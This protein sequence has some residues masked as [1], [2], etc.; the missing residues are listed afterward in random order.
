MRRFGSR[1]SLA[2]LAIV[3]SASLT[4]CNADRRYVSPDGSATWQL[5]FPPDAAP[6][7]TGEEITVFLVE[8]RIELPVR[9]PTDEEFG[10]LGE[11]DAAEFTPYA[12]RP[13]A[14]RGDYELEIDFTLSNLAEERQRI[15][16]TI[17]GINEFH[18]YMPG[19]AVVGDDQVVDFSGWERTYELDPGE[20]IHVTIREEELDEVAVDLATVVNGAPNSN[21]IV[22]FQ[23]HSAHDARS[24][25]YIP[26]IVPALVGVRLGMRIEAGEDAMTAPPAAL[27][28]TVRVRDPEDKIVS[29]GEESWE[30]PEPAL[31]APVTPEQ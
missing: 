11:G 23:N 21:Q 27:E 9:A 13:W 1:V 19:V 29:A 7:F 22:F 30:L 26:P 20:R 15:A 4:A 6:F 12:R 17:N 25:M 5:A 31:F 16:V 18:E 10:A 14:R 28:A 24:Q 2:A 8:Q 3:S